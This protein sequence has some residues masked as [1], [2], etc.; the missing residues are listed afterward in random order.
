MV[1]SGGGR[2]HRGVGEWEAQTVGYK[3]GSRMY[4]T[5]WGLYSIFYKNCTW[6]VTFKNYIK[7]LT[8][9]KNKVEFGVGAVCSW[10]I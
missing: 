8:K 10:H 7:F 3:I 6:N 5:T 4:C 1:F 2:D 9:I